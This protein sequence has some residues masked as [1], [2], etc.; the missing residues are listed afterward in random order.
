THEGGTHEDGFKRA[1][2]KVIN[3]YATK[4]NIIKAAD[5]RLS[6]ED[7]R[8][9]LTAIVSLKHTDPQFEGHTTTKLGNSEARTITDQLFSAGFERFILENPQTAALIVD[10]GISDQHARGAGK[11]AREM[12][13]STC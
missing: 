8:E 2:T 1:L 6:G 3:S 7:V 10:R 13:Q 12:A 11:K 5:E 4:Q 9:G